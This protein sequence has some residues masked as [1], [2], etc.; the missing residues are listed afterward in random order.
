[1]R[2]LLSLL[3]L[4][5]N[6]DLVL[7]EPSTSEP[8]PDDAEG[9]CAVQAIV[10]QSC[11]SCHSAASKLGDLDLE[12]DAHAALVG[13]PAAGDGAWTLV[14][15]GD[16]DASAFYLKLLPS[17]PFGAVMPPGSTLDDARLA[18]I[19]DWITA[20][21]DA[22]C[23]EPIDTDVPDRHHPAGFADAEAHGWSAKF[24]EEECTACHGATLEGTGAAVSCD[25]CHVAGWRTDCTFCH[26]EPAEGSGAPPLHISGEDD[27]ADATFIP[28]LKHTQATNKHAPFACAECHTTPTE[29]LSVGHLFVLDDTSGRAEATFTAGLSDAATWN[30]NG[31]CSNLYCHG[32]GRG[33]NG[34]VQHTASNL[35]CHSCHPDRTS[36]KD[37]WD[38]MSGEHEKHL[39]EGIG[40]QEC[41]GTTASSSTAIADVTLHVNGTVE[42]AFAGT[43]TRSGAGRCSGS[44]HGEGHSNESW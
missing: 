23:D 22:T 15:A 41:H 35:T 32:N 28:H 39:D 7:T 33:D 17:P 4:A 43:I 31:G 30:G 8:L 18:I 19:R 13:V 37:A 27:G 1:M 25:T 42:N 36:G 14:V 10:Q 20:G 11:L 2:L 16:A 34:T 44:C 40:C 38:R 12:T 24:Q 5:C 6:D 21:A 26:G 3:L 29:I 9:Y